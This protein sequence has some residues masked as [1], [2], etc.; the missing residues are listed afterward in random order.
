MIS[1]YFNLSDRRLFAP[2]DWRLL[3]LTG[4][5]YMGKYVTLPVSITFASGP[6]K[7]F[8]ESISI[9]LLSDCSYFAFSYSSASPNSPTFICC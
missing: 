4:T 6:S 7:T 2:I 8:D 9:F 5:L 1:Q 3:V